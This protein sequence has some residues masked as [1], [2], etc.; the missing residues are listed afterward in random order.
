MSSPSTDVAYLC[1]SDY[2]G[3]T[4]CR[5]V[6]AAELPKRMDKGLGWAAAGQALTPFDDIAD[7]PWGPMTEVRQTP[8]AE[9]EVRL[10]LWPGTPAFHILMCDSNVNDGANWE[11]C[12]RGFM[13]KALS[14][15]EAETGLRFTAAFEHEFL[16]TG[17]D[18][19][20]ATP[21]S[22]EAMRVAAGFTGALA[23]ALAAA[24]LEPQTIEPEYGINQYEVSSAP[25]EGAKAGD[26]A[27]LT[28]EVI[29]EVAR[30]HGYRA[31]FTPKPAPKAVG[32][33]A[34][35]HFSFIGPDG[36]NAA[37]DRNGT[38]EASQLAQHFVAGLVRHLPDI[39]ALVAGSP[40]SYYRL[41]PHHWS[42]GYAS[43]GG[44]EPRGGRAHLPLA[45]V[46]SGEAAVW[47]Q[48]GTPR[49]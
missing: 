44:A 46:R 16:L 1:W 4:R 3:I 20:L 30:R 33:G 9:T 10:D 8:R 7:N 39:C 23:E 48:H 41:G 38:A 18:L 15:F 37:Y 5:G 45:R 13:K 40:V 29:R 21:F 24:G 47:L 6:P 49:A 25:A 34:H 19:P 32:N 22:L 17:A 12:T 14:D 27:V 43:F 28:R 35:V 31:S 2:V 42:C 36:R 26:R 11:C